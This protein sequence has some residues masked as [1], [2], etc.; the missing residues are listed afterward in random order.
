MCER[1][2]IVL[3][4]FIICSILL[5]GCGS[6][7]TKQED[8]ASKL[9]GRVDSVVSAFNEGAP[10]LE[11]V[12]DFTPSDKGSGHY[13]TEFRLLAYKDAMGKSYKL[14]D[15]T[16]DFVLQNSSKNY[17]PMRIYITGASFD[18]CM[19]MIKVASHLM[20]E[21]VSDS[22]IQDTLDYLKEHKYANGYSYSHLGILF[23]G[24]DEHGY[25]MMLKAE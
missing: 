8:I 11:F 25:E 3:L 2:T 6:N 18:D 17:G 14:G 16:I 4:S 24:T 22:Q 5:T 21:K 10:V 20:D 15:A 12:E 1:I 19:K 7:S 23:S 13:R 9:S